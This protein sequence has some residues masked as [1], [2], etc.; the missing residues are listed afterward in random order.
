LSHFRQT[1]GFRGVHS[2]EQFR[3][4][5]ERE[6]AR[7][8]RNEHQ[9]SVVVFDAVGTQAHSSEAQHLVHVLTKRIRF[10]DQL[11]WLDG[12]RIAV[13][14]PETPAAGAWKLAGDASTALGADGRP[15][16]CN[17]YT[18]PSKRSNDRYGL[19]TRLHIRDIHPKGKT[20]A[21][22]GFL[23]SAMPDRG[24][25]SLSD[26]KE[27]RSSQRHQTKEVAEPMQRLFCYPLPL[28]KRAIDVVGA[29][30]CLV[31]FSPL[32]LLAAL[33]IK[34]VS[35]G[36]VFFK[37]ERAGCGGRAFTMWKFRTMEVGADPSTHQEYV[38]KL[39][40]SSR[41]NC[42]P[43]PMIKLSHESQVIPLGRI[44]RRTYIDELP[45]LINVLR[46]EMSLVGPRPPILYELEE[47]QPWHYKRIDVVPGMTGLWQVSGKN[48]LTFDEMM[49]LDIRYWRERS[50]WLDIKI[51]LTTPLAIISQVR[52]S[53]Q[54]E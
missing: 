4:I 29:L 36:P 54:N 21:S 51:L 17:V 5:L 34:S 27:T 35:P 41:G 38:S 14:L 47:Y 8:D 22:G 6:R 2:V 52:D 30:L 19:S 44:L 42:R 45:Q 25:H 23:I 3:A 12:Q 13:L 20:S 39:I 32:M 7:A 40:R 33:V 9:F 18:Y 24:E 48:R 37:Q 43:K 11:G 1:R 50:L 49:R 16:E 46:G 26:I 53:M 10:T 31:I 28:W 15:P